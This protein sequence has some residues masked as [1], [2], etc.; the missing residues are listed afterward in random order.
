MGNACC[1]AGGGQEKSSNKVAEAS[2]DAQ[3]KLSEME[4]KLKFKILLLVLKHIKTINKIAMS[5][6]EIADIVASLRRNS[7]QC[8]KIL[9]EE[10]EKFGFNIGE[11]DKAKSDAL[12]AMEEDGESDQIDTVADAISVLWKNDAIQK[13]WEKKDEFW[14]LDSADF[15]FSNIERFCQD[16]FE[17]TE[18]DSVMARTMT[19]GIITTEIKIAPLT[20]SLIDVGGQRNER[21]KWIHTMDDCNM[22]LYIVNLS[23]Y[24]SVL[25]EDQTQNRMKECLTLFK[26]TVNNPLF[27]S[28]PIFLL[29]NKKDLFESKIRKTPITVCECFS[30]YSGSGELMDCIA[31]IEK[32]FKEQ[33]LS[34]SPDRL[35][36]FN[37]AARFKKDVKVVWDELIVYLKT[38]NKSTIDSALKYMEQKGIIQK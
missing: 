26:Q 3:L 35:K 33:I 2:I 38:N 23:G 36:V 28:M 12:A 27:S 14:I 5:K 17:P 19:T 7:I 21:R 20:F 18:E 13:T 29:F 4:A 30:D 32:R 22:I 25:F 16:D 10:A 1:P 15:Y 37:I 9:I 8:M 6:S 11:A 34:G 24:N 31:F